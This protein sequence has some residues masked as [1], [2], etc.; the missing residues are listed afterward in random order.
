MSSHHIVR[1]KQEP[2][3][4]LISLRK[5]DEDLLGQ[6]LEWSPTILV[7]H[8]V[9]EEVDSLGIKIDHVVGETGLVMQGNTTIL[10]TGD[11]EL[12]AFLDHLVDEG[13]PAVNIVADEMP[14]IPY[15]YWEL[16]NIVVIHDKMRTF[17][18]KSGFRVWKPAG[19]LFSFGKADGLQ[20]SN[21]SKG[22][23]SFFEVMEDN[24]VEVNFNGDHLLLTE[25]L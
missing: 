25:L 11:N 18:I 23:G 3:L 21:T 16:L 5:I 13:Y 4:I 15:R 2:A 12:L 24:F 22:N 7:Y 19:T 6:L 1:A 8:D 9:Y 17:K 20:A 14:E 10:P